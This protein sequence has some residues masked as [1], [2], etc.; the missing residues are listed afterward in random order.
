MRRSGSSGCPN[1][2]NELKIMIINRAYK[3]ELDPTPAQRDA[4][5]RFAGTARFVFNWA[6]GKRIEAYQAT[7][8]SLGFFEQSRELTVRKQSS[9]FNWMYQVSAIVCVEALRAVDFAFKNFF[10]RCKEKNGKPGFPKFKSKKKCLGS[11]KLKQHIHVAERRIK[12]PR[13]G[14]IRLK[15]ANYLPITR[16]TVTNAKP[17][18]TDAKTKP[19]RTARNL[20]KINQVEE[21]ISVPDN[22]GPPLHLKL[23]NR[24]TFNPY[25]LGEQ[26]RPL[27]QSK[28]AVLP[29]QPLERQ[30][31]RLRKLS[32]RLSRK[33]LG[34]SNREKARIKLAKLH[35]H[36]ASQR[37]DFI[38][39][40]TTTLAIN[41]ASITVEKP[42][43]QKMLKSKRF[44]RGTADASFS[45]F[46]RQ[47]E[48]KC[49]WYGSKLSVTTA[50]SAESNACGDCAAA[51]G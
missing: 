14:W 46:I 15:E 35:Y 36:I 40:I 22:Q 43:I 26:S 30:I 4:F 11:F 21:N 6:L 25:V 29:L 49:E 50:G 38:H 7:G 45:E 42:P 27:H 3:T 13:L 2:R 37:L 44:A 39:K 34:S 9:E 19:R 10:R 48:Y 41:H 47:L 51:D 33:Q 8:K 20:I 16:R 5:E 23:D 32:R 24:P 31:R 18:R 1:G 17:R 12:L 28:I